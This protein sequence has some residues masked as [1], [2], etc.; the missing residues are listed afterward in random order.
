MVQIN[1]VFVTLKKKNACKFLTFQIFAKLVF[2]LNSQGSNLGCLVTHAR[3]SGLSST[4]GMV[5]DRAIKVSYSQ[6]Y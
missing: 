5:R 1:I 3:S 2:V 4:Q 6:S